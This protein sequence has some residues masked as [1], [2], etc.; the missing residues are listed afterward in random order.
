MAVAAGPRKCLPLTGSTTWNRKVLPAAR[1]VG[2]A[3]AVT[4]WESVL[5]LE[6][7]G[8]M[9]YLHARMAVKMRVCRSILRF[10]G[11]SE[12]GMGGSI[13]GGRVC[14]LGFAFS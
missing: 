3:A 11:P 10:A 5:A 1:L 8:G 13:E 14:P 4:L 6:G 12:C 2:T 7:L 9:S